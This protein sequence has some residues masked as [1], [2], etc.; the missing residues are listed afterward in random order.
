LDSNSDVSHEV[1]G[2]DKE[3]VVNEEW[4]KK[5]KSAGKR[6][7]ADW[8]NAVKSNAEGYYIIG[9]I[10]SRREINHI[11]NNSWNIKNKY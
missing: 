11:K 4:E 9:P 1:C 6:S 2:V 10:R 8:K 5:R 7:N 3:S